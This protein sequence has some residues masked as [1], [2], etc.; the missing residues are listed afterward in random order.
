MKRNKTIFNILIAALLMGCSSAAP[1]GLPMASMQI[2]SKTY[3][4]EIATT[5]ASREHGLMERDTLDQDHGMIFVFKDPQPQSSSFWMHHTRFPL[6]IIFADAR[7]QIVTIATMKAYDETATFSDGPYSY[8]I[9]LSKG[10]AAA[11]GVKPGD[12]LQIPPAVSA[13]KAE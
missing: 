8:A 7:A 10:E 12:K 1:S 11:T 6:D 13:I 9:E 4:L 5:N 3:Q 2:G